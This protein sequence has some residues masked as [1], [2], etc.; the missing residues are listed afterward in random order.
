MNYTKLKKADLVKEITKRDKEIILKENTI[1]SMEQFGMIV[2][3][4]SLPVE[5]VLAD[6]M[7]PIKEYMFNWARVRQLEDVF[8]K[9]PVTFGIV[10]YGAM[11]IISG[12]IKITG[13]KYNVEPTKDMLERTNFQFVLKSL[14][15]DAWA[16]GDGFARIYKS[17]DGDEIVKLQRL[18]P[19]MVDY[20]R[21]KDGEISLDETGN[22]I[23]Y[24]YG[25]LA[26]RQGFYESGSLDS[27]AK[28]E[29]LI[30]IPRK[31]MLHIKL[32]SQDEP[33]RGI[34]LIGP[35]QK[36][37]VVRMNIED[38]LGEAIYRNAYPLMVG[39]VGDELHEPNKEQYEK[40]SEH[41][42]SI[43]SISALG[44]PY[45]IK[46]DR[47][48][49]AK[50]EGIDDYLNHFAMLQAF[51]AG[52]SPIMVNPGLAVTGDALRQFTI[53]SEKFMREFQKYIVSQV[54]QQLFTYYAEIKKWKEIPRM[55]FI[56][57]D[58]EYLLRRVRLLVQAVRGGLV[59]PE[60]KLENYMRK[61]LG[62]PDI[63]EKEY[64]DIQKKIMLMKSQKRTSLNEPKAPPLPNKN[65]IINAEPGRPPTKDKRNR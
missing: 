55:Q 5:P 13:K 59:T 6:E 21:N 41:L 24:V 49:P 29:K 28:V 27:T 22:P 47:I 54:E 46:I 8:H 37:Y 34:S 45:F 50:L 16:P 56:I 15:M 40:L 1:R 19:S 48:A 17:I 39:Y 51:A 9:D 3:T 65:P 20:I 26:E 14:I 10:H 42:T 35:S 44:L 62:L 33:G 38:S 18:R 31:E 53:N 52:I 23:G 7:A 57:D 32:L 63:S 11:T 2:F 58:E 61:L 43:T 4:K 30:K 60:Y 25:N 36:F 64:D 12:G